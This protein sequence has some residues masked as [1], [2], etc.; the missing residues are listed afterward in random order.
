MREVMRRHGD[1]L[2]S[3]AIFILALLVFL[4]SPVHQMA[5]PRYTLVLTDSLM[6]HGTFDLAR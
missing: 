3:A 5:D 6:R 4:K 2:A 1:R